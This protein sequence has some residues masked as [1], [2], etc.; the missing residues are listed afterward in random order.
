MHPVK[1]CQA[2]N[3]AIRHSRLYL[4]DI[5]SISS[6]VRIVGVL[7][8][9]VTWA[10]AAS[11]MPRSCKTSQWQVPLSFKVADREEEQKGKVTKR[12]ETWHL[13][14]VIEVADL[15]SLPPLLQLEGEVLT[16]LPVE[17]DDGFRSTLKLLG[18]RLCDL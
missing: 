14:E 10:A 9:N 11:K 3:R 8:I 17:D 7:L 4:G 16:P 2:S 13:H 12:S 1:H 15:P 6:V 18:D 5:A